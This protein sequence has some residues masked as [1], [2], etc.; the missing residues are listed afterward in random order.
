M[1]LISFALALSLSLLP[2]FSF[3]G[4]AAPGSDEDYRGPITRSMTKRK[5]AGSSEEPKPKRAKQEQEVLASNLPQQPS[6]TKMQGKELEEWLIRPTSSKTS[7]YFNVRIEGHKLSTFLGD[8]FIVPKEH[9][10]LGGI[11]YTHTV[12]QYLLYK[13]GEFTQQYVDEMKKRAESQSK[14]S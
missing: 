4:Q 12:Y 9:N 10:N 13:Y 1:K 7:M 2:I 3:T 14:G 8:Q 6:S 11:H 5:E